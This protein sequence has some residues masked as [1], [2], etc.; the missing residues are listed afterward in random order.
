M[1]GRFEII[2]FCTILALFEMFTKV[3]DAELTLLIF[4][5][6]DANT[7]CITGIA[8]IVRFKIRTSGRGCLGTLLFL[9]LR[10][11]LARTLKSRY[12]GSAT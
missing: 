9:T 4:F 11:E 2:F 10:Q 5:K 12:H 8:Y 6:L 3:Q 7:E 1:P